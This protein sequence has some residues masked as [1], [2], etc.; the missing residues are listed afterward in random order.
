MPKSL[1]LFDPIVP[2]HQWHLCDLSSHSLE[3][4]SI[5]LRT[6][7]AG[8]EAL[9]RLISATEAATLQDI[10]TIHMAVVQALVDTIVRDRDLDPLWV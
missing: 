1:V 10:V 5:I 6:T 7:T 9:V 8:M 4:C 2:Q 3:L